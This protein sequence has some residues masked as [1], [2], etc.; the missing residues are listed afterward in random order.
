[1]ISAEER[2]K[3]LAECYADPVY[4]LKF[5]LHDWFPDT[6]PWFHRGIIA[7]ILRRVDFLEKYGEV[8]KIIKY[9]VWRADPWDEKSPAVPMFAYVDGVLTLKITQHTLIMVPRGFSKTTLLNGLNLFMILYRLREFFVYLSE[10]GTHSEEQ[11]QNLKNQL[12][13]NELILAFFGDLKPRHNDPGRWTSDFFQTQYTDKDGISQVGASIM[14]RGRG[15]QVRGK[16]IDG[17]RPQLILLDD[18]ED[19]ES[20]STPEQRTKAKKWLY[21]DVLPA[22]P[23]RDKSAFLVALATLL[24]PDCLAVTMSRDPRFNT[25]IFGAAVDGEALWKEH[26]PMEEIEREKAAAAQVGN[27]AGF[28]ME[29]FNRIRLDETAKFRQDMFYYVPCKDHSELQKALV[30]DPAISEKPGASHCA[31]GVVGMNTKTG[32]HHVLDVRG[33]P[34]MTPREQVD[35]FFDLYRVWRPQHCGVES[36]NYQAALIHLLREEMFR[37]GLYFEITPITHSPKQKK[38]DRINGI[39]QPRYANGYVLH[40]RRFSQL[41]TALLDFPNGQMDYPDVIAMCIGLLDPYAAAAADPDVDLG[42]DEYEELTD[43][44]FTAA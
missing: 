4:F 29:L 44:Y 38:A 22:L 13:Q 36:I 10:A 26:M 12:T 7:I 25:V 5:F 40:N 15:G 43:D 21:R 3:V 16:N 6:I 18:V 2:A 8:D 9:F 31:F 28:Y 42:A 20:V 14:G 39:L 33:R 30:I 37:K 34:G 24:G 1:M 19:L 32:K 41:E 23:R 27:L 35:E 11:L 17:V